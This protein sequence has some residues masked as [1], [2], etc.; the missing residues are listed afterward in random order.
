MG[1][2][3]AMSATQITRNRV[4]IL[5][6]PDLC[7]DGEGARHGCLLV[8]VYDNVQWQAFIVMYSGIYACLV[9][10]FVCRLVQLGV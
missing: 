4:G 2:N 9:M 8:N 7:Q 1:L 5:Q 3:D 6:G 10:S